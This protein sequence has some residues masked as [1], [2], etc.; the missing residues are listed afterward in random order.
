MENNHTETIAIFVDTNFK[1]FSKNHVIAY[2]L[3]GK[4]NET[5]HG[6]L[7]FARWREHANFRKG[8]KFCLRENNTHFNDMI[9]HKF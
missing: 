1:L 6:R 2:D 7:G 4:I 9:F 5:D 3:C 8:F